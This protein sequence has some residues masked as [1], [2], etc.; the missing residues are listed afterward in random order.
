M[1]FGPCVFFLTQVQSAIIS[2]TLMAG[3]MFILHPGDFHLPIIFGIGPKAK[4]SLRF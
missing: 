4:F 2:I 1:S 3:Q